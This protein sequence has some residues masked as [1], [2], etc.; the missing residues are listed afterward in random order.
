[1]AKTH[2]QNLDDLIGSLLSGPHAFSFYQAV[3]TL[4]CAAAGRHP[5]VG[6]SSDPDDDFVRFGQH[7]DLVH[8]AADIRSVTLAGDREKPIYQIQYCFTGLSGPFGPMP[9]WLTE[10]LVHL[11]NGIP[12]ETLFS[13]GTQGRGIYAQAAIRND[14]MSEF[15]DLFHHRMFSFLYRAWSAGNLAVAFDR[16]GPNEL[17][18]FDGDAPR[19]G[20]FLGST[21]GIGSDALFDHQI[22]PSFAR[23][24]FAGHLSCQTRHADGLESIL[25]SFFGIPISIQQFVGHWMEIPD[26]SRCR[27][28]E[29][30]SSATL[31]ENMFLGRRMWDHQLKIR[32]RLGPMNLARMKGFLPGG[33]DHAQLAAWVDLYTS[34]RWICDFQIVIE[35]DALPFAVLGLEGQLGRTCWLK[36]RPFEADSDDLILQ[37]AN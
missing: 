24:A 23:L 13:S 7:V 14:G 9:E 5:R 15:L 26:E 31:G 20:H 4:E 1:M 32:I 27:L 3:R 17:T 36:S 37:H 10:T 19:F 30:R 18:K 25:H 34:R 2:R 16:A 12:D 33:K 11:A 29:N 21:F 22:L 8:L 6:W 28:G 35:R